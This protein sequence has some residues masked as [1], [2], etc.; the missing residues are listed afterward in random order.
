MTVRYYH[1][2]TIPTR[3]RK[4]IRRN[5]DPVKSAKGARSVRDWYNGMGL[6]TA[7]YINQKPTSPPELT[8]GE[9]LWE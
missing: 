5:V 8:P 9:W 3:T 6:K 2:Y 1:F 4:A 7:V